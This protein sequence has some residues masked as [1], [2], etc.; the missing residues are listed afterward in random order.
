MLAILQDAVRAATGSDTIVSCEVVQTLWSG[1]GQILRVGI[2]DGDR[3]SVIV[4]HVA[5]PTQAN[6]PRGWA[7]D[8]SHQRKLQSYRVEAC[9]YSGWSDRCSSA[10][11]VPECL[12]VDQRDD[13]TI[14][15]MEDLNA[16]GFS[17]RRS[18]LDL[19]T[20][21][22]CLR[23]LASF[24]ATFLGEAPTGLWPT[25]TYWHLD[26]RPDEWDAMETGPLKCAAKQID[27]A[28]AASAFQTIVHGDAK[29][30]NFCF[31]DQG[32]GVA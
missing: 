17:Q 29:I 18:S 2:D 11:R 24:H 6:H 27:Q 10:C 9:W 26:T 21:K 23:W 28:L 19:A 25:G 20:I 22:T 3:G 5:P 16:A 1:Y 15:V 13:Q 31:A 32:Q 12:L 14:F 7:T 30:A 4:K 8:H